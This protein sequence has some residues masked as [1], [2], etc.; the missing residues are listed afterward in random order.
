MNGVL[1]VA[2]EMTRG[3]WKRRRYWSTKTGKKTDGLIQVD[4][5]SIVLLSATDYTA[6]S[7]KIPEVQK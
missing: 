3:P 5:L 6:L 7:K 2:I 1:A 4:G